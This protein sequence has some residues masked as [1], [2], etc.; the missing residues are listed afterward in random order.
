M[1]PRA[2]PTDLDETE[3]PEINLSPMIECIFILLI[4]FIV[5]TVF[6]EEAGFA[7]NKPEA[8]PS[9]LDDESPTL[10][11]FVDSKNRV[12]LDGREIR[13]DR[14]EGAVR[15]QLGDPEE[16]FVLVE[17]ADQASWGVSVQSWDAAVEAGAIKIAFK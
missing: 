11:I 1:P 13:L 7:G 12:H 10:R 5:T 9:S 15:R 8:A 14:L 16:T 17:M 3:E 6:I 4:F 2:R